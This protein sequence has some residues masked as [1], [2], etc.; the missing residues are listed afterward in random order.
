MTWN[1]LT[2]SIVSLSA[3]LML[4]PEVWAQ[5]ATTDTSRGFAIRLPTA[6]FRTTSAPC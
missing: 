5:T 2:K 6:G 1:V 3:L 4:S